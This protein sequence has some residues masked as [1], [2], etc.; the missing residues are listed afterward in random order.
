MCSWKQ[1]VY[2]VGARHVGWAWAGSTGSPGP[3]CG[4]PLWFLLIQGSQSGPSNSVPSLLSEGWPVV[5]YSREF[6]QGHW[7]ITYWVWS[8]FGGVM[9]GAGLPLPLTVMVINYLGLVVYLN[10]TCS[11][12]SL[13][14]QH[15][16][17]FFFGKGVK[18]LEQAVLENSSLMNTC[19]PVPTQAPRFWVFFPLHC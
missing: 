18:L 4:F 8:A 13:Q 1:R 10:P 7:F 9:Q 15:K 19:A 5:F 11:H 2:D 6:C 14:R 3:Q 17:T 12:S 16:E